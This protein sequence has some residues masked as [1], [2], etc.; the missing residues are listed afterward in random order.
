MLSRL[1]GSRRRA[2]SRLKAAL[3]ADRAQRPRGKPRPPQPERAPGPGEILEQTPDGRLRPT[4]AFRKDRQ[5]WREPERPLA[6]VFHLP[7]EEDR[8][9]ERLAGV[10]KNRQGVVYCMVQLLPGDSWAGLPDGE[11]CDVE[12]AGGTRRALRRG[13]EVAIETPPRGMGAGRWRRM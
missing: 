9:P 3:A 4:N 6:A 10:A 11:W 8:Y 12:L 13:W 2:H 1:R 7:D 5:K